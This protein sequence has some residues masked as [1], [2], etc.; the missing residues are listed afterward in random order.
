MHTYLISR[1]KLVYA[2]LLI[3]T[4]IVLDFLCQTVIKVL[5]M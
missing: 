1:I 4:G 2:V 3:G 5:R